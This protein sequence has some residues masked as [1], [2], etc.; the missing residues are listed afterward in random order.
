[1][2][3]KGETYNS[4]SLINLFKH[5]IVLCLLLLI[6]NKPIVNIISIL[7]ELKY[8]L[9]ENLAKK[10]TEEKKENVSDDEKFHELIDSKA[11]LFTTLSISYF[12]LK[13]IFLSF[14]ADIYVPPPR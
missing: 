7:T 8:E 4:I 1:M 14:K 9:Y 13:N 12:D 3:N 2:T 10:N 11:N 6:I 5:W